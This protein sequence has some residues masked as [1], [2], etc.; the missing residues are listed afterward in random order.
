[1][2]RGIQNFSDAATRIDNALKVAGLSGEELEKVYGRLRDSAIKNA[3]PV[4]SLVEL[5]GRATL[6]QKELGVSTEDLLQFTDK[7]SVA[8]RVQ[9]KSAAETQAP[10]QRSA[11]SPASE[12][13]N[14]TRCRKA[15]PSGAPS[16][17][18]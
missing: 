8:L 6:V 13:R 5:F 2:L 3:A 17:P 9:G 1:M 12:Q 4:E 7:V 18:G 15:P 11:L 14:T 16:L 10:A